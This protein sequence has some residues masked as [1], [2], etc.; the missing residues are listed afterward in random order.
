MEGVTNIR[1]PAVVSP[2]ISF[3]YI[4]SFTRVHSYR[5]MNNRQASLVPPFSRAFRTFV[6]VHF[7]MWQKACR[8]ALQGGSLG[9]CEPEYE[10]MLRLLAGDVGVFDVIKG[11]AD[12]W[13]QLLVARLLYTN[14]LARFFDLQ[15][16]IRRVHACVIILVLDHV[17]AS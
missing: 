17:D 5:V 14:P 2:L 4:R 8:E 1:R 13:C 12:M 9:M 11:Y 15:V 16:S 3:T 10:I 6:H 7:Q